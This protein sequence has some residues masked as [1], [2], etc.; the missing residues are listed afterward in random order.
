MSTIAQELSEQSGALL[1]LAAI[2]REMEHS[3]LDPEW[4]T[5]IVEQAALGR[6]ENWQG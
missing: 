1:L 2:R 6:R 5:E 3:D 4:I